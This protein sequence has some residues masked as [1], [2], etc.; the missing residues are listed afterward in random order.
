MRAEGM[1][2]NSPE[3][4]QDVSLE[5]VVDLLRVHGGC[6]WLVVE[7]GEHLRS[8]S[9][10]EL[11]RKAVKGPRFRLARS[12]SVRG[13]GGVERVDV[14]QLLVP[15][16]END[17]SSALPRPGAMDNLTECSPSP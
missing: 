15:V 16:R 7:E 3:E 2:G 11:L 14:Y 4:R 13:H 1:G 10:C 12:F 17:K 5:E 8:S 6:R 9:T